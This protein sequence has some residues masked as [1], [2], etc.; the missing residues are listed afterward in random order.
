MFVLARQL[1]HYS[2][3][4]TMSYLNWVRS[5]IGDMHYNLKD[6]EKFTQTLEALQ[7]IIY[8]ERDVDIVE[9]HAEIAISSPR[10]T[11]HLVLEYK[12]MLRTR[13]AAWKT[14]EAI[15]EIL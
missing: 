10:G 2:S 5:V 12:Q 1:F 14:P 8:Y 6:Q 13:A 7:Q 15:I 11:H 4:P 9:I 3:N